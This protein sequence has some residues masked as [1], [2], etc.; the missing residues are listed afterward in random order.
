MTD[1]SIYTT[2]I[3][4]SDAARFL[5]ISRIRPLKSDGGRLAAVQPD[6]SSRASG[7]PIFSRICTSIAGLAS[8]RIARK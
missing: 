2:K 8:H 3:H 6:K 7:N 1:S 4:K 5:K